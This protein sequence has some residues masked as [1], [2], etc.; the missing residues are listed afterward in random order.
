MESQ[1]L[2]FC[3]P[4]A[5]TRSQLYND[6]AGKTYNVLHTLMKEMALLFTDEVFNIGCDETSL[7]GQCT[8]QSTFEIERKVPDLS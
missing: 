2:Q 8:V 5:E 3:E 6:P 4:Q 7:K 1:G